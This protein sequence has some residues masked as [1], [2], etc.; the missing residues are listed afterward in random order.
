MNKQNKSFQYISFKIAG[1]NFRYLLETVRYDKEKF[2]GPPRTVTSE[3]INTY[4]GLWAN[5]K[6]LSEHPPPE[7]SVLFRELQGQIKMCQYL[8]TPNHNSEIN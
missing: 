1:Y 2:S 7:N 4:F 3:E 6:L 5:T 8:I